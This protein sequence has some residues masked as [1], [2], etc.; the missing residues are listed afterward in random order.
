METRH[1]VL[2][3]RLAAAAGVVLLRGRSRAV[4]WAAHDFLWLYPTLRRN[5]A[6]HGPVATR[7][8]TREREVWLTIDDGPDP[9]DTPDI[10]ALLAK[11]GAKASFFAIGKKAAAHPD[12]CRRIV[13]EGHSLENHSHSHPAALWWAMPRMPVRTDLERANAAILE[14]G[15]QPPRYFRSPVGMNNAGVH[16]AAAR[17]GLRVVGWSAE[18]RDGCP[19]T[20]TAIVRRIMARVCPGAILLL[21]E[22]GSSRHRALTLARLLDQLAEA[23]YRCVLPPESSLR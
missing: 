6:W 11:H 14:A 16:P 12:L 19:A 15:G 3:G 2:A 20:P 1:L 10:L 13:A 5:C 4:A 7:F 22:S 21:H 8:E 17:L 18:G 9:R 23:G